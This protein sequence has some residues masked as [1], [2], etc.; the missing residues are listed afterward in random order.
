ML[1]F[2]TQLPIKEFLKRL[3][4]ILMKYKKDHFAQPIKIGTDIKLV[5]P[6]LLIK[7]RNRFI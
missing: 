6:I 5:V 1:L 7:K 2:P 4:P 3:L